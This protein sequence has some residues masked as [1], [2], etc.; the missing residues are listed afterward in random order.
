MQLKFKDKLIIAA[1]LCLLLD[2]GTVFHLFYKDLLFFTELSSDV[3][4]SAAKRNT[5]FLPSEI[6]QSN[7]G[8][9]YTKTKLTKYILTF[10]AYTK[11]IF[12]AHII[13]NFLSNLQDKRLPHFYR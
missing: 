1:V 13:S 12:L 11:P 9:R 7:W 6:S 5:S 3:I 10:G 8:G 2:P 4:N